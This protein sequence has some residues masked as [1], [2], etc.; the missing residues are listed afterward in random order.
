[1]IDNPTITFFMVFF[2]YLPDIYLIEELKF[3]DINLKLWV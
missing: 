2:N 1:M 3:F